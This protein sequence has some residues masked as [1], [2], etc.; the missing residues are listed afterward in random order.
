MGR[1]ARHL[2]MAATGLVKEF[3]P[4]HAGGYIYSCVGRAGTAQVVTG[5]YLALAKSNCEEVGFRQPKLESV[6]LSPST[7]TR[8]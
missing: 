1:I 2:T 5:S 4:A 8:I 7:P 6:K 3:P